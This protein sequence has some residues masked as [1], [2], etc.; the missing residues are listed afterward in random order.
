MSAQNFEIYLTFNT[1]VSGS[2]SAF[3]QLT[4]DRIMELYQKADIGEGYDTWLALVSAGFSP[5]S[6]RTADFLA[7]FPYT[8]TEIPNDYLTGAAERGWI[9]LD[10]DVFTT[11]QKAISLNDEEDAIISDVLKAK[12]EEVSVDIPRLGILLDNLVETAAKTEIPLKPTFYFSRI[13]ENDD[14]TPSLDRLLGQM[15]SLIWYRDDC[16]ISS[17]QKHDLPGIVWE[18]L[19]YIWVGEVTTAE[20]LAETLSG[21]RGYEQDDYAAA[22]D[23]LIEMGWVEAQDD[24][25]QVTDTGRQVR[26]EAEAL[27]NKYYIKAFASLS[28]AELQEINGMLETLAAEIAPEVVEEG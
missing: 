23:Q 15:I 5:D 9:S 25:Y 14:K 19:S 1:Q 28:E 10:G 13:F 6:V 7:R 12:S 3:Y 27:T 26:E 20:K 18:A 11:T 17:W 2:Y 24:Q 21:Y 16:H 4:Q 8:K 22:I